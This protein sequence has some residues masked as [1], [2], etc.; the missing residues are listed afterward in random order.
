M[1][2][3]IWAREH[4]DAA[5][6]EAAKKLARQRAM[7]AWQGALA[8]VLVLSRE[9]IAAWGALEQPPS[10][11]PAA[12][13][14][15]GKVDGEAPALRRRSS[16]LHVG[17]APQRSNGAQDG[18]PA[19]G[20]AARGD[21]AGGRGASSVG[22]R[23]GYSRPGAAG[24]RDLSRAP[25]QLSRPGALDSR[26]AS[27]KRASAQ[28]SR[29]DG[30]A[31]EG[32]GSSTHGGPSQGRGSQQGQQGL[33]DLASVAVAALAE[34]K[35]RGGRQR[36]SKLPPLQLEKLEKN[37]Q[38][39]VRQQNTE[40]ARQEQRAREQLRERWESLRQRRVAAAE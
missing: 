29:T 27:F 39:A 33:S 34:H 6:S 15:D 18:L 19:T 10:A 30:G 3:S 23:S 2:A 13:A 7:R 32:H 38:A 26:A 22:D 17:Q 9:E 1:Q 36:L 12:M 5:A 21:M 24:A 16:G 37:W 25:S 8:K 4:V 31:A 11:D 35:R 28:G 20:A 14:G 40:R